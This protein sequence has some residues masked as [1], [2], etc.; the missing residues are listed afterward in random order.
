[1]RALSGHHD[2]AEETELFLKVIKFYVI[3]IKT[4]SALNLQAGP[5]AFSGRAW[6]FCAGA[7]VGPRV[8]GLLVISQGLNDPLRENLDYHGGNASK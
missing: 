7:G 5:R 4:L 2:T 6:V 1:M 3:I 8:D